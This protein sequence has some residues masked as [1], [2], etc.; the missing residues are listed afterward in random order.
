MAELYKKSH[1]FEL[2]PNLKFIVELLNDWVVTRSW[3]CMESSN[4]PC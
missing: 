4:S 2:D 3:I 1:H